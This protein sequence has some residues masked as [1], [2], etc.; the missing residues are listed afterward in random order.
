[1]VDWNIVWNFFVEY[2]VVIIAV[3]VIGTYAIVKHFKDRKNKRLARKRYDEEQKKIYAQPQQPQP[4][5]QPQQQQRSPKANVQEP[6]P[7]TK[8][9]PDELPELPDFR[10]TFQ[11]GYKTPKP[12]PKDLIG[13]MDYMTN[14][15]SQ[16]SLNLDNS[17][18]LEFE[19]LRLELQDVHKRRINI[20]SYGR[21]LAEVFDKYGQREYQLTQM[22]ANLEKMIQ[23]SEQRRIRDGGPTE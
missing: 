18:K 5:P 2:F 17:M 3:V 7:I 14:N 21:K 15:L 19:K 8:P 12:K 6:A 13:D 22:M 20:K 10:E 11:E 4:Q 23:E 1:M 16:E 9:V